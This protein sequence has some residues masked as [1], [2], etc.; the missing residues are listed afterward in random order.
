MTM[1]SKCIMLLFLMS[2]VLAYSVGKMEDMPMN[3]DLVQAAECIAEKVQEACSKTP[4]VIRL[5][6]YLGLFYHHTVWGISDGGES[7]LLYNS[8]G[9]RDSLQVL[10]H[11]WANH[12]GERNYFEEFQMLV[13]QSLELKGCPPADFP[14]LEGQPGQLLKKRN[15]LWN[16]VE[17]RKEVSE[18]LAAISPLWDFQE[19]GGNMDLIEAGVWSLSQ[20]TF[21][22]SWT[23]QEADEA[24]DEFFQ[25]RVELAYPANAD[26]LAIRECE[27]I[28]SPDVDF[29]EYV[30][31][32]DSYKWALGKEA[33][34]VRIYLSGT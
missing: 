10:D 32:T 29:A 11:A 31:S 15:E 16:A 25:L 22:L 2:L 27:W 6:V 26:N 13:A 3:N 20:E 4:G 28:D 24:S 9:D 19:D 5:E 17:D 1:K 34:S 23:W 21:T 12:S 7:V 18:V 8:D 33:A 14:M 30:R